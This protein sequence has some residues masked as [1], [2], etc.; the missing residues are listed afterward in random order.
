MTPSG[1][2]ALTGSGFR[3]WIAAAVARVGQEAPRIDALN[4][5]PV[6]DR[7]TGRNLVG[8]LSGALEAVRASS[9]EALREVAATAAE[10][11]LVAARG[12]SG[13]ILS[14]YLRGLAEWTRHTELTPETLPGALSQA[15]REAAR[16][17]SDPRPGTMLTVAEAASGPLTGGSLAEC[18]TD[19]VRL[20]K[21]A[22]A[23]TPE[24][25]P[26][27]AAAGVVD[28]GGA[29]LVA[30]LEGFAA[31]ETGAVEDEPARN[32]SPSIPAAAAI[33]FP[34]DIE[35]LVDVDGSGRTEAI[36]AELAHLGDSLIYVPLGDRVKVHVHT[37]R[38]LEAFERL[39][40]LGRPRHLEVWDMR[41]QA[42]PATVAVV[43]DRPVSCEGLPVRVQW[44]P[45][46]PS[47]DRPGVIW[48]CPPGP[49]RQALAVDSV[50]LLC[51]LLLYYQ[52]D[53]PWEATRAHL[54]AVR[55]AVEVASV[56]VGPGGF[57]FQE[58]EGLSPE[59]LVDRL[60]SWRRGRVVTIYADPDVAE[61]VLGRWEEALEG[62]TVRVAE[63]PPVKAEFLA[64]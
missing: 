62:A 47:H 51:H 60:K 64:E 44:L 45:P 43:A 12:N 8:T 31:A 37:D 56:T 35:A 58:A 48:L 21:A 42:D 57:G 20:A 17:V 6:A 49:L 11:A 63:P 14:Q 39:W 32:A 4:V 22:L 40:D 29:G 3:R 7:D 27:L 46:G 61:E 9:A 16:H 54:A 33:R 59:E 5:F 52:A 13:L 41:E 34:Y 36:R 55:S 2:G 28:A 25:L 26:E 10:G 19:A 53:A 15:A 23:K 18:L 24:L 30:M 38:P 1:R 50:A